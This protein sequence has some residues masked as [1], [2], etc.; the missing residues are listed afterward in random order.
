MKQIK[1]KL[2]KLFSSFVTRVILFIYKDKNPKLPEI[3][4]LFGT[5][6]FPQIN[7]EL[8]IRDERKNTLYIWRDDLFN[9]HGW[10]LPGGI[11]RPNEE[12]I[13]R[14][15]KVIQNETLIFNYVRNIVGPIS[16]SE[17]FNEKPGFRSHFISIVFLVLIENDGR[18]DD[19][20]L[21]RSKSTLSSSIPKPL[22][23]N[24]E[25]YIELLEKENDFLFSK[26]MNKAE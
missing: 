18:L 19:K 17:V 8:I 1:S 5:I 16:I 7:V 20:N 15:K 2:F 21:S 13:T 12:I 10:H 4:F 24:H 14:V 26:V 25:R 22:I 23:K 3:L 6:F 9:N 11:I